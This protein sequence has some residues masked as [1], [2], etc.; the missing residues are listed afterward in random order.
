M[1]RKVSGPV[2]VPCGTPPLNPIQTDKTFLNFTLCFLLVIKSTTHWTNI[3]GAFMPNNLVTA[4]LWSIRLKAFEKSVSTRVLMLPSFLAPWN[5]V[6]I[7][8]NQT[9][10][11][12]NTLLVTILS[13]VNLR[14]DVISDPLANPA[15]SDLCQSK[16]HRTYFVDVG[17]GLF[18]NR[19]DI[20]LLPL[21]G[22]FALTQ[23]SIYYIS[24]RTAKFICKFLQQLWGDTIWTSCLRGR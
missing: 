8:I 11:G 21:G 17:R 10:S 16:W 6:V 19:N 23:R 1:Q 12:W 7:D 4:I 14:L 2:I 20:G 15:L 9:V 18:R 24:H 13:I 22:D 3:G 5:Y